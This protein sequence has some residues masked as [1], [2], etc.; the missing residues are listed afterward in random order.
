VV[1]YWFVSD[2]TRDAG[3]RAERIE[4]RLLD[5]A[6]TT[7]AKITV[8]AL[9]YFAPCSLE[10]AASV[11]DDLAARDR[12]SMEIEDDGT[13][14]Y[15]LRGRQK[16]PP[17]DASLPRAPAS[18]AAPYVSGRGPLALQPRSASPLLAAILTA[19]LPGA[20]HLYAGRVLAAIM[21][22]LVIGAGYVL[23][24]PGLILHV[25]GMVSAAASARRIGE[26]SPRLLLTPRIR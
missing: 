1:T 12:V 23:L 24:L 15:E 16:L 7:D 21:W 11:L 22:F 14:V 17:R 25:F 18:W 6:Y 19:F 20:G 2:I 26:V 4:Q 9:A 5:L 8:S 10:A 3:R 13:V